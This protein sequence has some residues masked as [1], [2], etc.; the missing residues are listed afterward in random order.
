MSECEYSKSLTLG[1]TTQ[2]II[3]KFNLM[4]KDC[5]NLNSL[6]LKLLTRRAKRNT[7]YQFELLDDDSAINWVVDISNVENF[8]ELNVSLEDL[9]GYVLTN[10]L[11]DRASGIED[12]MCGAIDDEKDITHNASNNVR[13]YNNIAENEM[14]DSI[15][16][17][18]DC[19]S[20][21]SS[22]N[23]KK[24]LILIDSDIR[25]S[26][27]NKGC[28]NF[29]PKFICSECLSENPNEAG[30]TLQ[31]ELN[32]ETITRHCIICNNEFVSSG[33][34]ISGN[35]C[36]DSFQCPLCNSVYHTR[37]KLKEHCRHDH[38]RHLTFEDN[39]EIKLSKRKLAKCDQCDYVALRKGR[40][41][42]HLKD[43]HGISEIISCDT[44]QKKFPSHRMLQHHVMQFHTMINVTCK[45]C[46]KIC[47]NRSSFQRHNA[48]HTQSFQCKY[49]EKVFNDRRSH[50]QHVKRHLTKEVFECS[51]CNRSFNQKANME[52]HVRAVHL[53]E[54]KLLCDSCP[55]TTFYSHILK[56]HVN[57]VH[58]GLKTGK[59]TC[60]YCQKVFTRRSTA[61]EH[62]DKHE[63][64]YR[65][66]CEKCGKKFRNKGRCKTHYA[67]CVLSQTSEKHTT[68]PE[69]MEILF[70][71]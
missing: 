49:C 5:K 20:E 67:Q 50:L 32:Y 43:V 54:G 8:D 45:I 14:T 47:K 48:S 10:R 46:G 11:K 16:Y 29:D 36:K 69:N 30:F 21:Q 34:C 41:S 4:L 22:T 61:E 19:I 26:Q 68:L 38:L 63:G 52:R 1:I 7:K 17:D 44:C 33:S 40:L 64:V 12:L 70:A 58:F 35:N 51:H 42:S 55:F 39:G 37:L 60:K 28:N 66:T 53:N 71:P 23:N 31:D 3:S 9:D 15:L 59:F 62:V 56:D 25:T 13:S 6:L 27:T 2:E 18:Q 65:Y 57:R 24:L